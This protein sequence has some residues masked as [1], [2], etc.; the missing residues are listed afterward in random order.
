VVAADLAKIGFNVKTI[1]VTHS[2]MYTRF[3]NV[4][5]NEPN[6]C[7][8]VGWLPDFHEPQAILDATFN[9][10][11]ITS[12]NNSN[13]PLLNVPSLNKAM[14]RAEQLVNP[15]ARYAA[16]G[17][18]DQQVTRT[19]AAIPWLWEQYPTLFSKRVTPAPELWNGGGPDVTFMA[20]NSQA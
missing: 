10:K 2:T 1:S 12:V 11:N 18:I 8:N 16:W 6:I 7:P 14:D 19:A 15:A 3:C 5:K 17:K 13:W 9:G 4:P 20:V